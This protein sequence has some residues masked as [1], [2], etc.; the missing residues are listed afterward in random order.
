MKDLFI[1]ADTENDTPLVDFKLN[2][3]LKLNGKS[4]PEDPYRFYDP[5]FQWIKEF[6]TQC[7]SSVLLT[8]KLDY[9]NTSTGKLVLY[10]FRIIENIHISGESKTKIIWQ[11]NKN[12]EDMFESGKDFKSLIDTPFESIEVD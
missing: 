8:V 12:D 7:P 10:L 1:Q 2:G 9:F 5:I 6:R 4:F 3:D 11:Y